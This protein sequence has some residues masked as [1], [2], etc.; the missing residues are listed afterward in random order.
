[1]HITKCSD[2]SSFILEI[3]NVILNNFL[4]HISHKNETCLRLCMLFK[5]SKKVHQFQRWWRIF[6]L[7]MEI[8]KVSGNAIIDWLFQSRKFTPKILLIT[9]FIHLSEIERSLS[10]EKW[11]FNTTHGTFIIYLLNFV[12]CQNLAN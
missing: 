3:F 11:L 8:E 1:M 9:K 7:S 12:K 10:Y 6:V 4:V 2:L 5:S